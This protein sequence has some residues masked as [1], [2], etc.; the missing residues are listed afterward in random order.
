MAFNNVGSFTIKPGE[1]IRLD[2]WHFGTPGEDLGAQYFSADPM[3][4]HPTLPNDAMLIISDQMKRW[5]GTFPDGH[6]EYG[7]RI[8]CVPIAKTSIFIA[9]FSVQGGGFV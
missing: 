2:G 7:F 4:R 9:A 6:M 8:T 3:F 1:S 5:V